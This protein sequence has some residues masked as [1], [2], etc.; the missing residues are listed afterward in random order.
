MP[1]QYIGFREAYQ[2]TLASIQPLPSTS[3]RITDCEGYIAA[4]DIIARADS[5]SVSTSLKDGYA[6][7]AEDMAVS[8]DGRP[9]SLRVIGTV[10]AGHDAVGAVQ[11][12]TAMRVLT[13]APLPPQADTIVAEEFTSLSDGHIR[14]TTPTAR[15]R[16]ILLKGS[17]TAA[18]AVL[19]RAGQMMTPGRI[20]LLAAGGYQNLRVFQKPR[21]AIIA[22]GDEILLPGQ[23]LEDGKLYAS[24]MLTLNGWCRHFGFPAIMDV[25]GDDAPALS[26]RIAQAASEQD[27][28]VTSGGAWSGDKD[29]MAG[30]LADLGWHKIYHRV[31]LGPGKAVGFGLLAGKP[32]FILPGGPPSNLVAF[33]ELAL[34]ALLR[35]CGHRDAGLQPVTAQLAEPVSG[36][37]DWTQAIFGSLQNREDGFC[38]RPHGRPGSRL[39]SMAE[40]QGL[41][42]IPEGVSAFPAQASVRVQMLS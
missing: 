22:T 10:A 26:Q 24:N 4:E 2:K 41:L 20:G 17:D 8:D 6:L 9:A 34:P 27:A 12:G 19:L 39:Q 14:V 18:G 16:N 42:L 33:L 11:A 23:P 28:I 29:L 31:R 7:R 37:I 1:K 21:I 25:V 38:F 35:L 13:G 3:L 32:V 36:Q 15:G 30:V 40:A 5:P